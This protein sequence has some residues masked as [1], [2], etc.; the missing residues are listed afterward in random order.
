MLRQEH[1]RVAALV[2]VSEDFDHLFVTQAFDPEVA[3]Q[4]LPSL[5]G[6]RIHR[7]TPRE[8]VQHLLS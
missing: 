1:Y 6:L 4:V 8:P 5:K 2:F 3:A 7:L